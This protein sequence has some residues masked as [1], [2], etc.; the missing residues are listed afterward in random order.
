MVKKA[1]TA[2]IAKRARAKTL[3]GRC[4]CG[5]VEYRVADQFEYAVNCHCSICRRAT[6][7]AF[8]PFAGIASKKLKV[9]KGA[10]KLM[11]FGDDLNNDTRCAVCGSF[12]YSVVREGAFVHV[13]MGTLVDDP[14]IRVRAHIFAGSK[15]TW[16]EITDDLPQYEEYEV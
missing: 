7:A 14:S 4:M 5:A 3:L 8:K 13:T 12:L 10:D 15:A 2:R 1:K 9:T 6:G 11:L 16:F